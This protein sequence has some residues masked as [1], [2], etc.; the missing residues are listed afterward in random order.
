MGIL[1]RIRDLIRAW[2]G[3]KITPTQPQRLAEKQPVGEVHVPTGHAVHFGETTYP[4]YRDPQ[5]HEY[6]KTERGL[7]VPLKLL[8]S[9]K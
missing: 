5:G 7:F 1:T 4:V 9:A 8:V 2:K 6:A 3:K